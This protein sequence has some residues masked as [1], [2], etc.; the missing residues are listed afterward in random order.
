MKAG[1]N[2]FKSNNPEFIWDCLH[3]PPGS[4][5]KSPFLKNYTVYPTTEARSSFS[6]HHG[7]SGPNVELQ[8]ATCPTQKKDWYSLAR[9]LS[10]PFTTTLH[11]RI[12]RCLLPL[13]LFIHGKKDH[14]KGRSDPSYVESNFSLMGKF[15]GLQLL[16]AYLKLNII[17]IYTC[18]IYICIYTSF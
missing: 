16:G 17:C 11:L 7:I 15:G 14:T 8:G 4:L 12:F 3:K 10:F 9:F 13:L 18:H 1:K 5:A 6:N 2:S